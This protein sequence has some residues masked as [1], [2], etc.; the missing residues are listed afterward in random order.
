MDKIKISTLYF[1]I[2]C[3]IAL[4][5]NAEEVSVKKVISDKKINVGEPVNLSLEITNPFSEDVNI[6]ITDKNVFAN[7]GLDIQC[8]ERT[9][10]KEATVALHY[11]SLIAYTNGEFTLEPAILKY[12]DPQSGEK[13][14]AKSNSL[15]L[16]VE[17][18]ASAGAGSGITAI[19]ECGGTSM[20][21]TSYSGGSSSMQVSIGSNGM[22][23]QQ[24]MNQAMQN[25]QQQAQEA[26]E[27][28]QDKMNQAL[29]NMQQSSD[30]N[31][32]R[33]QMQKEQQATSQRQEALRK[34]I[35]QSPEF[36]EM[37]QA[38]EDQGFNQSSSQIN[39]QSNS[40]GNFEYSFENQ[41]GQ[42]ATLQGNVTNSTVHNLKKNVTDP[43]SKAKEKEEDKP[44]LLY[45]W[46][47]TALIMIAVLAYV[48]SRYFKVKQPRIHQ[49]IQAA[50]D[51]NDKARAIL[52]TARTQYDTGERKEAYHTAS[53]A[54][55][56]Y[57]THKLKTEKELT[58]SQALDLMKDK[59]LSTKRAA[60]CF[61]LCS[62]VGFAKYEPNKKDFDR[63][64]RLTQEIIK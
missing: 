16:T 12:T 3:I 61:N 57:L 58:I 36:Q 7:N 32:L 30:M 49:K 40:T 59:G 13:K 21:S 22:S 4:N 55:R 39:A 31:A 20:R 41:M 18:Q 63:I 15:T 60:E 9:I 33:Q 44:N 53:F 48:F 50:V 42:K 5:V 35:E 8:L 47:I 2:I 56:Y 37:L 17:G 64:M 29:Q 26:R 11:D 6:Q 28:S 38:L 1:I 51:Y 25:A 23:I 34:Q 19:Y 14:E 54:L 45:R 46:L 10:P 24:Q 52:R 27:H 62:M 43:V